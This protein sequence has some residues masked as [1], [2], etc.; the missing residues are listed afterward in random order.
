MKLVRRFKRQAAKY[1]LAST[2]ARVEHWDLCA[3]NR[4]EGIATAYRWAAEDLER[5][6]QKKAR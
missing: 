1:S 5:E 2:E 6:C 3:S 4:Y